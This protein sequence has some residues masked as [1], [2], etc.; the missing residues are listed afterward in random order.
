MEI[1]LKKDV[2]GLG[3]KNDVVK[4]KNG[5]ARNYLIP[6]GLAIIATESL[7]K[8]VAEEKK[9]AAHKKAFIR[10]QAQG[11]AD[12]L[13]GARVVIETLAGIDGKLF[14]SV[15]SLQIAQKLKEQGFDIDRKTIQVDDI[16]V[17]GDYQAVVRLHKEVS[18]TVDVEVIKQDTP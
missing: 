8:A 7:K 5:Y 10:N 12:S 2:H 15:T 14:G 4:V 6:Q 16:K 11:V 3:E 9:Q 18:A 17:L 1:I 13:S